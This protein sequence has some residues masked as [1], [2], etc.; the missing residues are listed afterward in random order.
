[1]AANSEK[2][3]QLAAL[4]RELATYEALGSTFAT[5]CATVQANRARIAQLNAD[6]QNL[7]NKTNF[8]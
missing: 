3:S 1:M 5:V 6:I 7:K 2:S 8:I 4:R